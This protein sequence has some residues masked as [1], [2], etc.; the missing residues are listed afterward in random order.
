MTWKYALGELC[1]IVVGVSIAMAASAWVEN[2]QDRADEQTFL[3][4]LHGDIELAGDLSDRVRERRIA[5]LQSLLEASDAIHG[6]DETRELSETECDAIGGSSFFQV[7]VSRLPVATELASTGRMR[8][9]RN[10]DLRVALVGLSQVEG[11]FPVLLD[12]VTSRST[13]FF[14][15]HPDLIRYGNYIDPDSGEVRIQSRCDTAAIRADT[16]FLSRLAVNIDLYDVYLRDGLLPWSSH[17]DRV[18]ELVDE[19]LSLQHD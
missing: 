9:I 19:E 4:R 3:T 2:R 18:H 10:A 14:R 8:I 17:F 5:L 1:L 15:D 11:T 7:G 12:Q 13:P 16:T 6:S